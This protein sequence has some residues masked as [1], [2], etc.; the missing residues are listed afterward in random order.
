MATPRP[1]NPLPLRTWLGEC[2]GRSLQDDLLAGFVATVL[3]VPQGMA[4]AMLAGL[5]PILGLYAGILPP[6]LYALLGTSRTLSV[7][8]VAVTALLVANALGAQ[9]HA[10]GGEEW[11]AAAITLSFLCAVLLLVMGALRL[12]ELS[13][14]LSHPVLSGFVSGAVVII[15]L[16]Q[17]PHLTGI[18]LPR[19]EPLHSQALALVSGMRELD[20]LIVGIG[21][22]CL[23]LLM[24]ARAQLVRG[25]LALGLKSRPAQM[26]SRGAPLLVVL[27]AT[28]ASAAL[29]LSAHGLPVVGEV[30]GGLPQPQLAF[31]DADQWRTLLPAALIISVVGYVES[32]SVAKALA[33][34]RRQ[35][36]DPNRELLALGIA[37]AGAAVSG[38]LPVA[39]SFSRSTVNFD[40]GARTPLAGVVTALLVAIAAA[41]LMPLFRHLPLAA[42]AAVIVVAVVPLFDLT[43]LRHTWEYDRADTAALLVTFLGVVLVDI[44]LGLLAGLLVS[45]GIFIWRTGHPHMAVVGRMPGTAHYRNIDRFYVET[46]PDL[47]LLR[48]DESLY[49]AN[50]AVLEQF[51][52][53]NVSER[54]DLR[55]VVLICSAV[56]GI[57]HSAVETLKD[58]ADNLGRTGVTLHL[59]EVKGPVMDRLRR[60]GL[61]EALGD[62]HVFMSTEEAVQTLRRR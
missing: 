35:R 33:W 32:V 18:E 56:N 59:A 14:F 12:G 15:I 62:G 57:D 53:S 16:S 49:F 1:K 31:L 37:N 23:L 47:L 22:V 20:L 54:S 17:L 26:L 2:R 8:P 9:G 30:R 61:L 36:I 24:L 58:L 45:L 4:L 44:E 48:V 43:T 3:L 52:A 6:L 11:I 39:G 25:L 10:P 60:S 46:W 5:P 7:G 38:T 51:I 41:L 40:A 21:G 55:H 27:A 19:G 42:L 28:A 50:T 29:E 13:N 34:R